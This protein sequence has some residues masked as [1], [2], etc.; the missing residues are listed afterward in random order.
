MRWLLS[1]GSLAA[2]CCESGEHKLMRCY[3]EQLQ[4]CIGS[5]LTAIGILLESSGVQQGLDV[6]LSVIFRI[7]A[8]DTVENRAKSYM[9]PDACCQALGMLG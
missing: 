4:A 6:A 2:M 1:D 5:F 8:S 3:W 9:T 7:Y